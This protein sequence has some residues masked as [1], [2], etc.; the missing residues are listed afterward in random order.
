MSTYNRPEPYYQDSQGFVPLVTTHD[1]HEEQVS[2][3][4]VEAEAS[5]HTHRFDPQ[6][7]W[8]SCGLREDNRFLKKAVM[9]RYQPGYNPTVDEQ[10]IDQIIESMKASTK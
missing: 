4:S 5:H 1:A 7:G 9:V 2:E 6:S 8:C 10:R 3:E